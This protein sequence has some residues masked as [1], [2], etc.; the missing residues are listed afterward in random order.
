M[1]A[2]TSAQMREMDEICERRH[3]I[4]SLEL[5]ENAGRA[6][7]EYALKFARQELAGKEIADPYIA[8][9]CGRGNNGGDGIATARALKNLNMQSKVFLTAP[10]EYKPFK[11]NLI[12]QLERGKAEGLAIAV[13]DEF[14]HWGSELKNAVLIIDALLGTGSKGMPLGLAIRFIRLMRKSGRPILALDVPSGIDSDTGYHT[15][16]FVEARWTVT[17]GLPKTGLLKPHA[18]RCVGELIVAG[19]GHPQELIRSYAG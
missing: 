16:V 14:Y 9:C 7:A 19:I 3:G 12:K 17:L 1:R 15:G 18:L 11:P 2:V 13:V 4:T 10:S 8:V 6:V 5:M